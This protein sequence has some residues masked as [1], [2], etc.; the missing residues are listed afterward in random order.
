MVTRSH[1]LGAP[2]AAPPMQPPPQQGAAPPVP[3]QLPPPST[4][5]KI[6]A[7]K[8]ERPNEMVG[9]GKIR[10]E[11]S[12]YVFT[13]SKLIPYGIPSKDWRITFSFGISQPR[14][15]LTQEEIQEYE[16]LWDQMVQ[17]IVANIQKEAQEKKPRLLKERFNFEI[18]NEHQLIA[19]CPDEEHAQKYN[20]ECDSLEQ[21]VQCGYIQDLITVDAD[22]IRHISTALRCQNPSEM[23]EVLKNIIPEQ[24][25][26]KA[27]LAPVGL[28]N[29][30]NRC[31]INSAFLLLAANPIVI[32]ELLTHPEY[33]SD[34]KE[35]A[36]YKALEAYRNHQKQGT[37][38]QF[39]PS[40]LTNL[41]LNP[42]IQ[43][44]PDEALR[45]ML[46]SLDYNHIPD[47][48]P[49]YCVFQSAIQS[50]PTDQ[51][52][53]TPEW[54]APKDLAP[55]LP[56][57]SL[58]PTSSGA[59]A[60]EKVLSASQDTQMNIVKK[61][62]PNRL[63]TGTKNTIK[64]PPGVLCLLV[65]RTQHDGD[66][67]HVPTKDNTTFPVES[68][69]ETFPAEYM[70]K[71]TNYDLFA[72]V[73]H[74][75]NSP[76][77]GHF[78]TASR[79]KDGF[80][81]IDNSSVTP[82]SEKEF[83]KLAASAYILWYNKA[84]LGEKTNA[85]NLDSALEDTDQ[86][87]KNQMVQKSEI[88][89]GS[90]STSLEIQRGTMTAAGNDLRSQKISYALVNPTTSIGSAPKNHSDLNTQ[91]MHEQVTAQRQARAKNGSLKI[92]EGDTKWYW[93]WYSQPDRIFTPGNDKTHPIIHIPISATKAL[94][95]EHITK[96]VEAAFKEA[97]TQSK[98]AILFPLIAQE[99]EPNPQQ[100]YHTLQQAI[101][102]CAKKYKDRVPA[103]E[104]VTIVLTQAQWEAI[105]PVPKT[106]APPS[107]SP[108]VSEAK[109][110]TLD[111]NATLTVTKVTHSTAST[112]QATFRP[113]QLQPELLKQLTTL[114]TPKRLNF[115]PDFVQDGAVNIDPATY[116][117]SDS[118]QLAS[119]FQDAFIQYMAKR[120]SNEVIAIQVA[121]PDSVNTESLEWEGERRM[122]VHQ[123]RLAPRDAQQ[124][125]ILLVE[126]NRTKDAHL[127]LEVS[128]KET[129]KRPVNTSN[130]ETFLTA[131]KNQFKTS[132]SSEW[133]FDLRSPQ[134][135]SPQE[136][137]DLFLETLK[138]THIPQGKTMRVIIH[139]E[140]KIDLPDVQKTFKKIFKNQEE[141]DTQQKKQQNKE[142]W[143][144]LLV[145]QD[146]PAPSL[147]QKAWNRMPLSFVRH[148]WE[149]IF[150]S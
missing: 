72:C 66:V 34:N 141:Q 74:Y 19:Y 7:E 139:P 85:E 124:G 111:N 125:S 22:E 11:D 81:L 127:I 119:I 136:G 3:Q 134:E 39:D 89:P 49:L 105:H 130:E 146:P 82:I 20:P 35:N 6:V 27:Y 123:S 90:A 71:A 42:A 133:I 65:K 29:P 135:V 37:A 53:A 97:L 14:E 30:D 101:Q 12:P 26:T 4:K 8:I 122:T 13:R 126:T 28:K 15:G 2:P 63:I 149:T 69:K 41:K 107:P 25:P 24:K 46:S 45:A 96:V 140:T 112:A 129:A 116:G 36:L 83:R 120:R 51:A 99:T 55:E 94:E 138:K 59:T 50:R 64:T 114:K 150:D 9:V 43:G 57:I 68:L 5:L 144:Q 104:K 31:Y 108:S 21:G 76:T 106:P 70:G 91:D 87:S 80:K 47:T 60:G 137:W 54:S 40:F 121:F 109:T 145:P 118:S 10:P 48:S 95:K 52:H 143:Q 86:T 148:P 117:I 92:G 16:E 88:I 44:D 23:R 32:E 115:C 78:V 79:D 103:I 98:T 147:W 33:F 62:D 77:G 93:P 56:F 73:A 38:Y 100:A 84:E 67:N 113:D 17:P 102:E 61:D 18:T 131:L 58:S 110:Y 1:S 142:L 128:F 75:G 132:T